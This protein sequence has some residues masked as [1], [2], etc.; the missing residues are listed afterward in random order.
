M[1]RDGW[2]LPDSR[3]ALFAS[4]LARVFASSDAAQGMAT[5]GALSH[6]ILVHFM[7]CLFRL[8][9]V[10]LCSRCDVQANYYCDSSLHLTIG[11]V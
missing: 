2:H 5:M 11:F 4:E 1:T 10:G 3:A 8:S 6:V 9:M 7:Q